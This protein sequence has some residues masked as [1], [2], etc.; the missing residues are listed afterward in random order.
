MPPFNLPFVHSPT[1]PFT[2]LF[3]H[4]LIHSPTHPFTYPFI[5]PLI[6]SST[7]PCIH[8]DGGGGGEGVEKGGEVGVGEGEREGGGRGEGD[9]EKRAGFRRHVGGG[10]SA[11]VC[12][13]G[14]CGSFGG[15][16]AR[17]TRS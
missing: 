13:V 7:H 10:L 9:A 15:Y 8:V 6:R 16:I 11:R 14:G 3:I 12:M 2:H 1:H 4:P 17:C 5:H